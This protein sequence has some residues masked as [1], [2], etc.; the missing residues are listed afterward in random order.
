MRRCTICWSD[1]GCVGFETGVLPFPCG[2]MIRSIP[3]LSL[4][5]LIGPTGSGK[6]S[7]ARKH[8]L[9]TEVVS[10]DACRA[11]VCDD[12]NDQAVTQDAFEVLHDVAA[13]RLAR[14]RLTV[15]DATNVQPEAR[16]PLVALARSY[17]SSGRRRLDSLSGCARTATASPGS[18]VR[19]PR[20]S[21]SRSNSAVLCADWN[22]KASATSSCSQAPRKWTP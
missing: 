22:A 19:S 8:F 3:K 2:T 20:H 5:V 15:V 13:K 6:S 14:G 18:Q 10:S 7:F 11:M 9:P 12:Q 4:V 21:T 16:K 17:I 1:C